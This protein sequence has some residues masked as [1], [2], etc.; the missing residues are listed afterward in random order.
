MNRILEPEIM[1]IPDG[2]LAYAQADF[3][4][5]N[6]KFVDKLI[7]LYKYNLNSV[8]DIGCGSADVLIR[9]AAALPNVHVVGIDASAPMINIAENDIAK[10][11]LISQIKLVKACVPN[12]PFERQSFDAVIS[13]SLL[14][15][16]PDPMVFWNEAKLLGK[17]GA[18]VFIMDLFRPESTEQAKMIVERA[19]ANEHE[20][21]KQDFY[22]SLLAAFTL[23]E[24]RQQLMDAGLSHFSVS[25]VSERHWLAH[26]IL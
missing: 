4:I 1:D 10:A 13:N 7:E 17:K 18:T 14:H 16:L 26:G 12:L 24:V 22:N 20:L 19:A 8:L 6:Q 5:P 3:S 9:L 11:G 25:I 21:L 2:A 23:E 15:H